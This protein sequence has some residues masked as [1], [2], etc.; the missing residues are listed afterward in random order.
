MKKSDLNIWEGK[1]ANAPE[2]TESNAVLS[3]NPIDINFRR[4]LSVWPWALVGG[5]LGALIG[6]VYLRYAETIYSVSSSVIVEEDSDI[7]LGKANALP[8]RD[9]LNS[10]LAFF[11]SPSLASELVDSLGLNFHAV[12]R[13][14]LKDKDFYG[15]IRWKTL[16]VNASSDNLS[17]IILPTEKGFSYK[18]DNTQGKANWG[19]PFQ[20]G[21]TAVIVEKENPASVISTETPIDCFAENRI[22]AAFSL[23]K[24]VFIEGDP[25]SNIINIRY[26]DMSS[27]RAIDVVNGLVRLYN[28]ILE[29]E[30]SRSFSQAIEFIDNRILPLGRELDSI[31]TALAN[32]KSARGFIGSSTKGEIFQAK[33]QQ[34][35]DQLNDV[36]RLKSNIAEI[37]KFINDPS[38]PEGSIALMGLN[39]P[40]VQGAMRGYQEARAERNRLANYQSSNNPAMRAAENKMAEQR[41]NLDLQLLIYK[42]MLAATERNY[43]STLQQA[44]AMLRA[45]PMQEKELLDKQRMMSIKENLFLAL[46]QKKEEASISRASVTVNTKVLYPPT[47]VNAVTSPSQSRVLSLTVLIGLILPFLF[48]LSKELL[49]RKLISKK[50][51]QQLTQ[52]PVIAELEEADMETGGPFVIDKNKRSVFG[53][54]IRS[55]RT[56]LNFYRILDK[57]TGYIMITSSMSGEGKTFL[58]I[59][60]ARSFSLQGKRVALLEFDLRKPKVSKQFNVPGDHPG[61]SNFLI[62][63]CEA[64]EAIFKCVKDQAEILDLFVS[65]PIPPN[66]QELM[67]GPQMARLKEYLEK[68][69]DL[70]IIDTPPFGMVA[71]AQILGQWAD[72]SLIV[73]RHQLS[74]FEQVSEIDEWHEKNLLPNI[75]IVL[76]GVKEKGYFGSK[77]GY[78]SYRRKYGYGYYT[79]GYKGSKQG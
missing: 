66:P 10:K 16:D 22:A 52:A 61:I 20:V 11:R 56:S 60:L 1:A 45:T 4:V 49:N 5:I 17:F 13:G 64:S 25:S 39:D 30:K 12:A 65:G 14:R 32:Y 36:N 79:Y 48:A 27:R 15:S 63:K 77:Y 67:M 71:D 7:Q 3:K 62:Q 35:E 19:I 26:S 24:R 18:Y 78:Y 2:M 75:S 40:V 51:L 44:D 59:N 46:L 69:Y 72:V 43:Q 21:K 38:V 8:I 53:E 37:E 70:V 47:I 68:H 28:L 33:V 76:N 6:L 42:N 55:L 9:P 31:Q 41:S 23:S 50:Q 73:T 34:G 74:T 58:S 54:Q 57:P 29:K